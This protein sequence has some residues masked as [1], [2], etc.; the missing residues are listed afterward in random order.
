MNTP[1]ETAG[2]PVKSGRMELVDALRGSAL[3][4]ILLLHAIEHWELSRYP[5]DVQGW[6][7]ALNQW[8]LEPGFF[9]FGGKA[10]AVFAMMFGVSFY[11][12]LNSWS[13]REGA[14]GV[15][16]LWRLALLGIF[17]YLNGLF[18]CGDVLLVIALLG[19]PLVFLRRLGNR[20]LFVISLLLLL[21][22]PT[23]WEAARVW[24]VPGFVQEQPMHWAV[25]GRIVPV[26]AEGGL[27]DVIRINSWFGQS[28]RLLWTY[29][30]G[31]YLQM[32]GL[33][34]WGLLLARSGV[35]HEPGRLRRLA[36]RVL[37][38]GLAAFAVLQTLKS[39]V[40]GMKLPDTNLH[41]LRNL[42]SAYCNLSQLAVWVGGFFLIYQRTSGEAVLRLLAPFGR[43]SL[44]N[45]V[46]QGLVGV[47][48]FYAFGFGL[49]Q[50]LGTFYSVLLGFVLL[51]TQIVVSKFWLN[52]F[53]YGPLEWL[54]RAL[55]FWDFSLPM[56]KVRQ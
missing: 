45:Y 14:V 17:G 6:L 18:Y 15:R 39:H 23:L 5:G 51:A 31:R 52:R 40:A 4:C 30:T 35:L 56:R 22:P 7:Q 11:L 27:W 10:Y 41:V 42:V 9:L 25:F 2:S 34:I 53:Q 44:T 46:V 47:P 36:W 43:M 37:A 33:F 3:A 13:R 24:F 32:S 12:I 48:L 19:W 20:T 55:T 49:Y 16:F 54:W 38:A 21:Q 29:E 1:V 8:T 50:R 26:F 28:G